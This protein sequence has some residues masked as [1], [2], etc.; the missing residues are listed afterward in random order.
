MRNP[1]A[2]SARR[3]GAEPVV[4]DPAEHSAATPREL[5]VE[6]AATRW[7][8]HLAD[9]AG[10]SPLW[11]ISTLGDALVELTAAH[12][13][14]IAQLYAGRSTPLSNLVREG[15]ALTHARRRARV[16]L[17]RT[18]E[19]AQRFG[20]A[21]TY[22]AMGVAT[23]HSDGAAH[24]GE[25]AAGVVAGEG[26]AEEAGT[27]PALADPNEPPLPAA[28]AVVHAPV[29][30][31]P[32]RLGV[33]GPEAEIDLELDPAVEVNSLLVRELRA[34]GV[35]V[36]A[37]A[38]GR[39]TMVEHGFTPRPALETIAE[40]GQALPGFS[41]EPRIVLGAFVHPGQALAEDLHDHERDLATHDV[42][43]ALAG[44][45]A[46]RSAVAGTLPEPD[47]T[48]RDPDD[49]RGVGDL[50]PAQQDVL[51]ALATGT[52]LL[53][54]APPGTDP[55]GTVAAVVAQAAAEGR[56]VLYVPGTRRAGQALV[57]ALRRVGLG[58][59]ALDLSN[60]PRWTSTAAGHLVEGL[61][62]PEPAI[63]AEQR[64]ADR[65]ALRTARRDL[66]EHLDAL[67]SPREPWGASA[68]DALQALAELTS[69]RPGPRTQVRVPTEAV[70]SM[71]GEARQHAREQLAR[72]A[73]LGAF[74]LRAADTPW[75]GARLTSADHATATLERVRELDEL[76][77]V[78]T[79]QIAR[80]A[81]QTGLDEA[82]TLTA[83][84]EQLVLLDG[85][86]SS[87][88]VFTPQVFERSPADMV[89]ATATR[90][91]RA[92]HD[93]N[94]GWGARRRLRKQAKDL[95]RP[96]VAVGDLHAELLDVQ[97]RRNVWR[98]HCAS[99]G[100]PRL[101]EG[102]SEILSTEKR[103]ADLVT[104]L[105]PVLSG[106]LAGRTLEELPLAEL[107]SRIARLGADDATLRQLPERAAVLAQLT[108]LGLADLLED[109][110][111]RRVATELV[112]AEFDLAWWSS[113][114]EE[115]LGEDPV[116]AGLDSSTLTASAETLREKDQTQVASLTADVLA[117]AGEHVRAVI[118]EDRPRA[119]EFY[120][121]VRSGSTDLKELLTRFSAVV[122][123]P[124]P[125]WVVPP[126]VVPQVLPATRDVD[127]LVLDA[128]QHVPVEQTVSAIVRSRQVV[129]VGDTRRGGTGLIGSLDF[130]PR[131]TLPA[132]RSS[133]DA[134][135]AAFLAA[136]GY[137]GVVRPLPEPP[138]PA[139]IEL[140]VVDG[141]GMPAP[142]VNVVESVQAEV[143]RVVDLVID[144]ALTRPDETLAVIALNTRHADRVREA[145]MS[146]AAGSA[147]VASFF[148]SDRPEAFTVVDVESAAGLRRDAIILTLGFGK[149]PHG[150]V[151]HRFGVIS[152][153]DGAEFLVDALDAV[154]TRLTVVSCLQPDDLD[155]DRLRA[156]GSQ[157][158]HGLL[159]LAA[160]GETED[161]PEEAA[162]EVDRLLVDLAERLWRRGLTVVPR[163]G[164]PGGVR[165]PLAV[166][167]PALPGELLLAV[168]T[169]DH[170]Y[171]AEPSLRRRDRHWIERLSARGWVVRT[172]YSSAVFMDPQGEA[173]R[174]A[175][176]VE[177]I[178]AARTDGGHAPAAV[179]LPEHVA[180]DGDPGAVTPD[181]ATPDAGSP[182]SSAP[183]AGTQDPGRS[184]PPA[185]TSARGLAMVGEDA[186]PAAPGAAEAGRGPRPDVRPGQPLS[187][188]GDDDFDALVAWIAA[189]G[190]PRT[191]TE[192]RDELRAELGIARRGTHVDAVLGAAARRSG[193]AVEPAE[194]ASAR[195][196]DEAGAAPADA[197]EHTESH[198]AD[199]DR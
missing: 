72:A 88:D 199:T 94:L 170:E 86:R 37:A 89:A 28:P 173:D 129:V 8:T 93:A 171:M 130:L 18:D 161:E 128:V 116:L 194:A 51:D 65:D 198:D 164:R 73:A 151:L 184:E 36:D 96:G 70:R 187:R 179:A 15:S 60:D 45:S 40:L 35:D 81:A 109:L 87:L 71:D 91:W 52:H 16:V 27:T 140:D 104:E 62:P 188:Y 155:P 177:E 148:D 43:A 79:D 21:P 143:D 118:A 75:F 20:V 101:P 133:Q 192:L 147:S 158:L 144:H 175:G 178:V 61:N 31:R 154:R 117:A 34:H 134:H 6:A 29:L 126:M 197:D 99:G 106:S 1:F 100:W 182:S 68:Y 58:D 131:L 76:M 186:A 54:D 166:G 180:E 92:Q 49:E 13:S 125:V 165:I 83:W 56:R 120:R 7:R 3:R 5:Q 160:D 114:L 24:L 121:A 135:L 22:V 42:V 110:T 138:G 47:P 185:S 39:S 55:A 195:P 90:A 146:V 74:R 2:G 41:L 193:L 168:L 32:V 156:A 113:V 33:H 103:V 163:Y 111:H 46:A 59:L 67:H 19:L 112:G 12:P 78:L 167:H 77:P 172:V 53:V 132:G 119:Q 139:R 115:I 14:G 85:I 50:D 63:D 153:P 189:D 191:V 152:G 23:W 38:I 123:A 127:L 136:H 48:D 17:A 57:D 10:N 196:A 97:S 30:L 82:A 95:V 176:A 157:M 150:R 124:R 174:I 181:A 142:G 145:V 159:H 98:R 64:A 11:D 105:N 4:P 137:E 66:G 44:V 102:M 26:G 190:T 108:D 122:W 149:T 162:P 141:T 84:S 80:T 25:A 107:T 69:A 9:L 169:D 183:A